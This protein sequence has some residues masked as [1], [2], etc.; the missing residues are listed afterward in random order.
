MRRWFT[1]VATERLVQLATAGCYV[2]IAVLSSVPGNLRPHVPGFSDKVEHLVAFLALGAVTAFVA[3]RSVS[4][5]RLLAVVVT[6]AAVLELGQ[7]FIPGR[8]ASLADFAASSAG[9]LLGVTLALLI[10]SSITAT[11]RPAD[12]RGDA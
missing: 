5:G 2:A 3:P 4:W 6:Y 12:F 8:V 7:A 11:T 9:A 1:A 10:R